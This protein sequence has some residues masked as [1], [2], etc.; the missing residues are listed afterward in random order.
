MTVYLETMPPDS[1]VCSE[2]TYKELAY[3]ESDIR[4]WLVEGRLQLPFGQLSPL[5]IAVTFCGYRIDHSA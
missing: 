3:R 5:C 4:R 2:H 1:K